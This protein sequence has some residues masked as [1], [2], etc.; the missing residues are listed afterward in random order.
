MIQKENYTKEYIENLCKEKKTDITI[1]ERNI[2]ALGLLEALTK[3]GLKF[4]F[5]GGTSLT[6]LLDNPTRL[7]TDIDIVVEPDTDIQKYINEASKIFPFKD[8]K[9]DERKGKNRIIKEHYSFIYESPAFNR[10][11]Y[12]LLDVVYEKNNYSKLLEKQIKNDFITTK[13]PY[14]SVLIPSIDCILA[15]KL[16]AFAPHTIGIQLNNDKDLEVIKQ[17]YDISCLFDEIG[18]FKDLYDSYMKIANTE[19]SYRDIN[20][21]PE[22]ALIDTIE[23]SVC[24]ASRGQYGTEYDLYLNAI[25][26]LSQ[27]I[28]DINFTGE[29]AVLRACKVMYIA[30]CILKIKEPIKVEDYTKYHEKDISKSKYAVL[31]RIRNLEPLGFGYVVETIDLLNI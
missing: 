22:D 21:S 29:L 5:K 19:I 28:F 3:A 16:T 25:N 9:K 8:V 4:I 15:D 23:S 6:I 30:S 26:G 27:H 20:I 10:N 11:F 7:S 17:M 14:N 31:G 24:I 2:Y 13:E 12:I 1:L 18:S